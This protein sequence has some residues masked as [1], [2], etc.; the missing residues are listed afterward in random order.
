[1]ADDDDD[2]VGRCNEV[3]SCP[4]EGQTDGQT[5]RRLVVA[6]C[7]TSWPR[8]SRNDIA[9]ITARLSLRRRLSRVYRQP[10]QV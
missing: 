7:F 3:V 5:D 9:Y 4:P 1:M 6:R 8:S 2:D 10:L